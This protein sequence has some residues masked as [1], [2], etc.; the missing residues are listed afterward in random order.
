M[1][2]RTFLHRGGCMLGYLPKF[3]PD[4]LVYSW[5]SRY[6]CHNGYP[7]Y[8][9]ALEDLLIEEKDKIPF[10]FSGRFNSE[11]LD[12]I[13]SMIPYRDI[14]LEHTMFPYYARFDTPN[15][16]TK[17][18]DELCKGNTNIYSLVTIPNSNKERYL[19]Y[20]PLCTL[21][22]RN[23]FGEA[24]FHRTH[25]IREIGVCPK[26]QCKLKE[27]SVRIC[28]NAS[29]RLHVPEE[30]ISQD[31]PVIHSNKEET[32]FAN[33]L[34]E[35]FTYPLDF[36]NEVP[37]G[38][39]L[40]SK[41]K[42]TSY[43]PPS[44]LYIYT[45]SL[46]EH[47]NRHFSWQ[48]PTKQ[49]AIQKVLS[50]DTIDFMTISKIGYFLGISRCELANPILPSKTKTEQ[51]RESI[52]DLRKQGLSF[53]QISNSL[54]VSRGA[55]YKVIKPVTPKPHFRG[56]RKGMQTQNWSKMDMD[57][58]PAIKG[59]IEKI[60]NG[61]GRPGRVTMRAI[62]KAMGWP[63]KRLDNL[64]T[65]KA[66]VQKNIAPI[67]DFWAKEV[68]WAY[69]KLRKEDSRDKI[70]WRDIRDIINIKREQFEATFPLLAKYTS[71]E[72]SKEIQKLLL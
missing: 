5:V 66:E 22:D 63:S 28:S 69:I 7:G 55:I 8:K 37:V 40:T 24:Y 6:Y 35:L 68:A 9:Q 21:E 42:E 18:L 50:G 51:F 17:A 64:P 31:S 58:L 38:E 47:L 34:A 52:A 19:S 72:I 70:R 20:C 2:Q 27:T 4:E 29:P 14:I 30:I 67:E 62:C 32:S 1:P 10:E 45:K 16:K 48:E 25:Q 61:N 43:C 59:A 49:Y 65:C 12:A 33:Y 39:F 60:L 26:H 3:Y 71:P 36:S 46:T 13:A 54:N 57:S 53:N 15:R 11:T 56:V 44:G 23:K 41:I